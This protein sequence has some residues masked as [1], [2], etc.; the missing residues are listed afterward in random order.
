[1]AST[2]PQFEAKAADVIGLDVN[3]PQRAAVFC[4]DE[5]TAIQALDR[6]DRALPLS[7]G[8]PHGMAS[9]IAAM[10][11]CLSM[12]HWDTKTGTVLGRTAPRHTTEQFVAFVTALVALHARGANSMSLWT[13]W[14]RIRAIGLSSS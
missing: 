14:P 6:R 12:P 13:T 7:P 9:S 3:P 2:D 4:L 1:M 8:G 5:K 10:A 11:R